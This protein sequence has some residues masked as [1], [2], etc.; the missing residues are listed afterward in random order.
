MAQLKGHVRGALALGSTREELVCALVHASA[1]MG[2]PRLFSALDAAG[3]LL[4][5]P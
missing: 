2:S 4:E 1:Y 5:E 3:E